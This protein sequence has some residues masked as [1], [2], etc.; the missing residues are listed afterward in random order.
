MVF[1]PIVNK[2]IEINLLC[3]FQSLNFYL[4]YRSKYNSTGTM[5]M[6]KKSMISSVGTRLG[7]LGQG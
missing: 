7:I 4:T 6:K 1:P 3:N 2:I 5:P